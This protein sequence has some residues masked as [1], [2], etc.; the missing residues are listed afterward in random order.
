V[1]NG[2][3]GWGVSRTLCRW[4]CGW[5][6]SMILHPFLL[7]IPVCIGLLLRP[8]LN[9]PLAF[10]PPQPCL[11]STSFLEST[12]GQ[13]KSLQVRRHDERPPSC[14]ASLTYLCSFSYLG[15]LMSCCL[16]A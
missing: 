13:L 4:V 15:T 1:A 2:A 8:L 12:F 14:T 16:D 5:S 9:S 10:L 3:L 6:T 11:F 7:S